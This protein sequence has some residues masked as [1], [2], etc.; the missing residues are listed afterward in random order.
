MPKKFKNYKLFEN[1][2][3]GGDL[4]AR[5]IPVL[6]RKLEELVEPAKKAYKLTL[7]RQES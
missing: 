3:L 5:T 1:L 2:E 6:I 7:N 4:Q